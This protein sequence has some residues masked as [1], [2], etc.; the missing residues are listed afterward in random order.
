MSDGFSFDEAMKQAM[1]AGG[2]QDEIAA[3]LPWILSSGTLRPGRNRIG[4]F[5]DPEFLW[6]SSAA[7]GDRSASAASGTAWRSGRVWHVRF[8]VR[9]EDF[10]PW[11]EAVNRF[12]SWT[13]AEAA[14]LEAAGRGMKS[15]PAT[16]WCRA[17]AL[18]LERVRCI[19]VRSYQNNR[20]RPLPAFD[21][22]PEG[23]ACGIRFAGQTFMSRPFTAPGGGTGY[24]LLEV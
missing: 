7:T 10:F 12:P 21:V 23:D 17:G 6:A 13:P 24:A 1:A 5:P 2:S 16:W 15:D 18:P 20:W 22:F 4:G 11:P 3:R 9:R 8:T 19:A 14:R